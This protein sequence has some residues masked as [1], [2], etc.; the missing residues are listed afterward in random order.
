M[1]REE[2]NPPREMVRLFLRTRFCYA[3]WPAAATETEYLD[4]H[5]ASLN[6]Q[7]GSWLRLGYWRKRIDLLWR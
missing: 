7:C 1:P 5:R 4:S 2:G 3:R 6:L